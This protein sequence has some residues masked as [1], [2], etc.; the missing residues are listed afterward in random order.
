M[1]PGRRIRPRDRRGRL[2]EAGHSFFVS[3]CSLEYSAIPLESLSRNAA[4]VSALLATPI[5]CTDIGS[6]PADLSECSAGTIF[7][8]VRSPE[9]PKMM[10]A[11]FPDALALT[12]SRHQSA[13]SSTRSLSSRWARRDRFHHAQSAVT[14]ARLHRVAAELLPHGSEHLV[15]VSLFLPARETHLQCQGYHRRRDRLV[16]RLCSRPSP[17]PGVGHPALDLLRGP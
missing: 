11:V 12:S 3:D 6:S 17:F 14:T 13:R 8:L 5:T 4:S 1:S 10:I 15:C 2:A 16:Y 9:A 7:R